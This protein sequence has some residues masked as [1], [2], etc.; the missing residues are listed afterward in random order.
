M[1]QDVVMVKGLAQ[2]D[3]AMKHAVQ[4]YPRRMGHS[5]EF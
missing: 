5:E 2:L 4:R 1:D 3:E